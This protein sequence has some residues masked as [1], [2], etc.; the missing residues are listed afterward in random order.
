M[1][2]CTGLRSSPS[3]AY[4]QDMQK[5]RIIAFAFGVA[6]AG[7]S[8]FLYTWFIPFV[9]FLSD[10]HDVVRQEK[11][12]LRYFVAEG[13]LLAALFFLHGVRRSSVVYLYILFAVFVISI[14]TVFGIDVYFESL[15]EGSGVGG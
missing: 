15:R 8:V 10:Y 7:W 11:N 3:R 13:V 6:A 1:R 14:M 12:L 4:T 9:G 5:N 2:F